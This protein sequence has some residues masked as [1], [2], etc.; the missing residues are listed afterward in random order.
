M[1]IAT[2]GRIRL[3]TSELTSIANATPITNATA[4]STMFP[5]N[6]KSRSSFSIPPSF[7]SG[8]R[9]CVGE[10]ARSSHGDPSSSRRA[11][12]PE[13]P[14]PEPLPRGLVGGGR[15]SEAKDAV[16]GAGGREGG[17]VGDDG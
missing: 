3:L 14:R 5:R 6:R 10:E 7:G 16:P 15:A 4:S 17:D 11:H 12:E 1:I 2:I 9:D 13:E 8:R